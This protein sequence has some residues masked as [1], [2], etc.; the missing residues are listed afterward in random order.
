M[1]TSV[2]YLWKTMPKWCKHVLKKE[3]K[4]MIWVISQTEINE[5]VLF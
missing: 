1:Q 3:E 2:I 4:L 5:L